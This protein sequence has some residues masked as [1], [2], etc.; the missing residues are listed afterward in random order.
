M[1]GLCRSERCKL[2]AFCVPVLVFPITKCFWGQSIS[3][4]TRTFINAV[5]V[6]SCLF[7]R[8]VVR[9]N[10]LRFYNASFW[11]VTSILRMSNET[12]YQNICRYGN[13]RHTLY[14]CVV[15]SKCLSQ[16]TAPYWFGSKN[17]PAPFPGRLS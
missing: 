11:S 8:M 15:S 3:V 12:N 4:Y 9:I 13:A 14:Y 7:K 1:S 16:R 10:E 6:Y 5:N 17:I 2:Y